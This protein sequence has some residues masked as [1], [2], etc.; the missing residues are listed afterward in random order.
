[1]SE[2]INMNPEKWGEKSAEITEIA[3]AL[4]KAQAEIEPPKKDA[5]NPFFKSK[6]AD[7]AS[8]TEAIRK[9]FAKHGLAILQEPKVANGKVIV[10]TTILHSSGQYFRSELEMTP[11]KSDPQG[12]GSAITYGRRYAMQAAAGV[13]PEDD[14]GN[15]ASGKVN[16]GVEMTRL[17]EKATETRKRENVI[18]EQAKKEFEDD[19]LPESFGAG[20]DITEWKYAIAAKD[21]G[22]REIAKKSGARWDSQRGCWVAPREIIE[23]KNFL[24]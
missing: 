11:T 17:V 18:K 15:A 1:M 16:N 10:A 22:N 13:A 12:I 19:D 7:L 14:D 6:Y 21:V 5:A 9:P 8:I 4:S 3:T 24:I 23:L 2:S 20:L